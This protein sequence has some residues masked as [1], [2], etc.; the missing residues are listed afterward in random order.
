MKYSYKFFLAL[1]VLVTVL[2][3]CSNPKNVAPSV[4]GTAVQSLGRLEITING[5]GDEIVSSAVLFTPTLGNQV[6]GNL[7]GFQSTDIKHVTTE[8]FATGGKR[9]IN[10]N[11][12]INNPTT[13]AYQNIT[14]VALD[15]GTTDG[16]SPFKEIK[17]YGGTVVQNATQAPFNLA[18]D[19]TYRYD[20]ATQ[21]AVIASA[22]SYVQGLNTSGI[23][24]TVASDTLLN[25]GFRAFAKDLTSQ[26]IPAGDS[27]SA[28]AEG[29]V[30]FSNSFTTQGPAT[31]PFSYKMIY[32]VTGEEGTAPVAPLFE[33]DFTSFR[34]AGFAPTPA[35][36]QL[37]SDIWRV[38]GL[39][40]GT[41]T[42]G[43]THTA[44][45]F[46]RGAKS[47]GQTTGGIYAFEITPG[48]YALGV[49]PGGSD[50]TPGSIT[51]KYTN[52]TGTT[53]NGFNLTY[54]FYVY[55]DEA[56]A[57]SWSL[58]ASLDDSTYIPI[59]GATAQSP[60][61]ASSPVAWVKIPVQV[62]VTTPVP[63]NASIYIRASTDDASASGARDEF[64]FDN[65]KIERR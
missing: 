8:T 51:F 12:A 25:Y 4:D 52:T 45:D 18:A 2:A 5:I 19:D 3:A 30:T 35:A 61:A 65:I 53:L 62:V 36:G 24:K 57:S 42:F 22:N 32:E 48:D 64:A 59:S 47:A 58:G 10:A 50:M 9:Y 43:G 14:M 41:G 37:D 31:D 7:T 29:Q 23:T 26:N 28:T 33:E 20:Y 56:R 49:Q 21:A 11:Y 17:N 54:D 44:G 38:Q 15:D 34:A 13:K 1:I 39:S 16:T 6:L 63:D 27:D 60:E 40:T 55:N 46:G